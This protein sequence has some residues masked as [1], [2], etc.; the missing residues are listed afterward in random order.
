MDCVVFNGDNLRVGI[1]ICNGLVDEMDIDLLVNG[2][3]K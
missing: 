3:G 1:F 2:G